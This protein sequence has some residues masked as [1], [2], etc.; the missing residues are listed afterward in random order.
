MSGT[1]ILNGHPVAN[2]KDE[3]TAK[4]ISHLCNL[5]ETLR[6]IRKDEDNF[7]DTVIQL[8]THVCCAECI[9]PEQMRK[10]LLT[11]Q[12]VRQKFIELGILE[13]K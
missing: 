6:D 11:R 8:F 3:E 10:D 5:G 7:I 9:C 13:D 2:T 12:Q 4:V 1:V